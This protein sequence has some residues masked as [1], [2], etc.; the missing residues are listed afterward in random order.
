MLDI[1]SEDP[2]VIYQF[3]IESEGETIEEAKKT[4]LPVIRQCED[5]SR[6]I[7]ILF[8]SDTPGPFDGTVKFRLQFN[9]RAPQVIVLTKVSALFALAASHK[10]FFADQFF[11]S[12]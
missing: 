3:W 9:I 5:F 6:S 8:M 1:I 2:N 12:K 10:L 7:D 11:L 4:I